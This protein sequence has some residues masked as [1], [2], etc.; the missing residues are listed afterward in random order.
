MLAAVQ[1][2]V[3]AL[4]ERLDE[5]A[6]V[7]G[8]GGGEGKGLRAQGWTRVQACAQTSVCLCARCVH[9]T[10]MGSSRECRCRCMC[11]RVWVW[12]WVWVCV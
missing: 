8:G 11:A 6:K 9:S 2:K 7:R 3:V 4:Q 12:V 1:K 10:W 5:Q